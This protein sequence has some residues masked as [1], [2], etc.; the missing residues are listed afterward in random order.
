MPEFIDDSTFG[1]YFELFKRSAWRLETRRGYASD[2]HSA[3][4]ARWQEGEDVAH[5]PPNP[6][7]QNIQRQTA[8]G[9]LIQRVRLVDDPP[10]EG[11]RFLLARAPSN[12][13]AGEEIRNMWRADAGRLTLPAVDFW[14]FDDQR[15]LVLHFDEADG[16]LGAEL[17]EDPDRIKRFCEIRDTAW[18][19]ATGHEEFAAKV[20][21]SA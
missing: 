13:S 7:R 15:A 5:D 16:Y 19:Q 2:R 20:A 14:L 17:V 8:A 12:I 21:S 6:W 4:W 10:T 18:P 9:K 11:Q 1:S 3:N